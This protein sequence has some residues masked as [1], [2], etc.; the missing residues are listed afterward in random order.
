MYLI[1]TPA[2]V[3]AAWEKNL[4]EWLDNVSLSR[5]ATPEAQIRHTPSDMRDA[6][7]PAL[8]PKWSERP[9]ARPSPNVRLESR[10]YHKDASGNKIPGSE[11]S[12]ELEEEYN[13][14]DLEDPET[15][16]D[17]ED[18]ER[19]GECVVETFDKTTGLRN[20]FY[21]G[22]E[23]HPIHNMTDLCEA[24]IPYLH[25]EQSMHA[26]RMGMFDELADKY[27]GDQRMALAPYA[28]C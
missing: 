2:D 10:R 17:P 24:A 15:S 4:T 7:P 21:I 13:Q 9:T 12:W 27:L 3:H 1:T 8:R 6:T 18:Q 14:E 23:W 5:P 25:A 26:F 28:V 19:D 22:R 11:T 16:E 20:G